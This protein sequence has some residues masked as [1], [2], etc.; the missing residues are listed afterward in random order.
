[1]SLGFC[2]ELNHNIVRVDTG[3]DRPNLAAVYLIQAGDHAAFVD[4]GTYH[5]VPRFLQA[6][7]HYG[8]ARTNVDYVIPTH[9]HLDH[10]GG[11][12]EL[13]RQLSHA[14]LVAHPRAA[15]HLIDP[16]RLIAGTSA[17]Y[18]E[19]GFRQRFGEVVPVP[20]QRVLEAA[21][22]FKLELN[23]RP[24]EFVDSPGHAR[25]H[26]CIYDAESRGFF[27]G[28]TFGISY[29]EFDTD[30]GP[31]IFATT[32]PPQF[33]P[34][35]W[36]HTLDRLLSY[37]PQRMYLTHF[38]GVANVPALAQKLRESIQVFVDIAIAAAGD[39][40]ERRVR[41]QQRML[42]QLL[43]GLR[44]HGCAL[45]TERCGEL[46]ATDVELNTQ[47]LEAWLDRRERMAQQT[48]PE[49]GRS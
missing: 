33:D 14:R 11:A 18:G 37:S 26:F 2:Q 12:G 48:R 38:G 45:T 24:L 23:G 13:M 20:A 42:D 34:D 15:P 44:T 10:A 25:H 7:D 1:M 43:Y 6:L 22:G 19:A 3:Y 21:D 29:R 31:F 5:C 41:I 35:A 32:T 30:N 36:F 49:S 17:V 47:G 4:T 8:I 16:T 28:D 46:L 9:A 40:P 39:S 27:V